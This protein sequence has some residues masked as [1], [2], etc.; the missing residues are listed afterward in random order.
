M[1]NLLEIWI[2]AKLEMLR[3]YY[4]RND[5]TNYLKSF[6]KFIYVKIQ[7]LCLTESQFI[8]WDS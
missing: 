6:L 2:D 3:K 7:I 4:M 8:V 5:L 1:R